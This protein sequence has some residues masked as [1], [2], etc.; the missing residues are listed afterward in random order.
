MKE[1]RIVAFAVA[2]LSIA[3][4]ACSPLGGGKVSQVAA[5]AQA[6]ATEVKSLGTPAPEATATKPGSAPTPAPSG[7]GGDNPLSSPRPTGR[8]GQAQELSD[9]V[10]SRM[11]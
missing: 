7:G 6:V 9:E 10:A 1:L 4:L 11:E 2:I 5:T 8:P 3:A